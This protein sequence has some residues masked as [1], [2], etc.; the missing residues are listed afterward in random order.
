[1]VN[2]TNLPY[3]DQHYCYCNATNCCCYCCSANNYYYCDAYCHAT[4]AVAASLDDTADSLIDW[5]Q[6]YY[7]DSCSFIFVCLDI[8]TVVDLQ[9]LAA[10]DD[11]ATCANSYCWISCYYY[12]YSVACCYSGDTLFGRIQHLRQSLHSSLH[13]ARPVSLRTTAYSQ[14]CCCWAEYQHLLFREQHCYLQC[15]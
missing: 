6:N 1:M 7:S 2:C 8:A 9:C 14:H 12:Q 13:L 4:T 11:N 5:D 15:Y 10:A 3:L